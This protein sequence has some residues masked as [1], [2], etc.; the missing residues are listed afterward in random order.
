[1]LFSLI[2]SIVVLVEEVKAHLPGPVKKQAVLD[3]LSA[4]FG[5]VGPA[6]GI[7]VPFTELS[8]VIS[9][10]IDLIVT[11]YN[12][13]GHFTHKTAV[14]TDPSAVPAG[15][16]PGDGIPDVSVTP[17]PATADSGIRV[18]EHLDDP[19]MSGP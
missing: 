16:T 17:A 15:V 5:T 10:L 19:S 6:A 3:A 1:M 12:T 9:I 18:V 4:T 8:G 2:Q 7:K 11:V 14:A 13:I